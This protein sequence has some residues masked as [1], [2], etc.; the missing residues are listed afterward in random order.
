M[1]SW[2]EGGACSGVCEYPPPLMQSHQEGMWNIQLLPSPGYN[3]ASVNPLAGHLYLSSAPHT[4]PFPLSRSLR[5]IANSGYFWQE[6]DFPIPKYSC[7]APITAQL[8]HTVLFGAGYWNCRFTP[9]PTF[10]PWTKKQ[11]GGYYTLRDR[12]N[13]FIQ[14]LLFKSMVLLIV[15]VS[16]I[17]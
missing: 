4:L 12:G 3:N 17:S 2:W 14:N 11:N 10:S 16:S 15:K 6:I 1:P 5:L 8:T 13:I 9:P 7:V